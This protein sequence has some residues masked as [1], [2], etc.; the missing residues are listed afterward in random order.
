[1]SNLSTN[2]AVNEILD[3]MPTNP[4]DPATVEASLNN[5]DVN[6][7][8][9]Y[10]TE[11]AN[12]AK[13][14][15]INNHLQNIETTQSGQYSEDIL[16]RVA[17]QNI[18]A[19]IDNIEVSTNGTYGATVSMDAKIT[20]CNTGAVVV[21]SSALPTGAATSAKQ[22]TAQTSLTSIDGK[23]TTTNSTLST[24]DTRVDGLEALITSTNTKL[25]SLITEETYKQRGTVVALTAVT[26]TTALSSGTQQLLASAALSARKGVLIHNNTDRLVHILFGT[27]TA[28][29]TTSH[30]VEIPADDLYEVP[31]YFS[32][33]A[34]Q[35]S[36]SNGTANGV[37]LVTTVN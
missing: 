30:S 17:L 10:G 12:G 15:S 20:A 21:S 34:I 13:L 29:P 35:F 27:G 11:V 2:G 33:V 28:N 19:G 37:I 25:D 7:A 14:D 32:N 22:D 26:P 5:I 16:S 3:L 9:T 36:I 23:L 1:M 24:I 4:F 8:N 6:T 18:D 31:Y